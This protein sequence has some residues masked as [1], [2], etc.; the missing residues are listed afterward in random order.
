M[1]P[2]SFISI[3]CRSATDR[4]AD[5]Q[6]TKCDSFPNVLNLYFVTHCGWYS[7]YPTER[8]LRTQFDRFLFPNS[9]FTLFILSSARPNGCAKR[10]FQGKNLAASFILMRKRKGF[11]KPMEVLISCFLYRQLISAELNITV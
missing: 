2:S 8:E 6:P 5:S 9:E 7:L 11:Q 4:I 10:Y 3:P 1:T